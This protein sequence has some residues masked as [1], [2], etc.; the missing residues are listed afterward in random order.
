MVFQILFLLVLGL[1][2]YFLFKSIS[3]I[4]RNINLGKDEY[5][6]DQPAKRFKQMM[7]V[8][9]GQKKMFSRPVPAIL[10]L[11]V[12]V[13]F[14]LI[15][16]EVLEILID[17]IAG[18]HRIFLPFL[19]NFY[20]IVINFFEFLAVMVIVVCVVFLL[21]RNVFK[22]R[23][24]NMP[25]LKRFPLFDA[26]AVLVIEIVL[27]VALLAMN[28][29]DG[30]LQSRSHEHYGITGTLA[31]SQF[32][33]PVFMGLTTEKLVLLERTFWWFH[34]IG[35]LLFANYLPYSKHLHILM[36][37]PNT[38]FAKLELKGKFKN[39]PVVTR[40][41]KSMLSI[42]LDED[43]QL[44]ASNLHDTGKFGAKDIPDLSWKNLMDAYSCTEC[45]RCTSSCPANI[46]GKKLSPR[47]IMMDTRDRMEEI[48]R[49]LDK[50]KEIDSTKSLLG[51]YITSE[52][53]LACT[54]CN[55]CVEEC[56]INIDPLDIIMQLRR[57]KIMEEAKAPDSWN[58]MFSNL[59]N[60]QAP[61]K[62]SPSDR[63]NW[64]KEN[65]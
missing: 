65:S 57:Y 39:M 62:F 46:T 4:K 51:D 44:A 40:E 33:N 17:G 9:F 53:L 34:I 37:F 5:L 61:W 18:T 52:E 59:E 29:C 16:I 19:G 54:T 38:Y 14:V 55:A 23:R 25:E 41:V 3:R 24:L 28:A 27:M 43:E 42:P 49:H 50:N 31:F 63:L 26:N 1:A 11:F 60:N 48:G 10:H 32:L 45:G 56:P 7:L 36:A 12:Y 20:T 13:G 22:V 6:G 8:A 2:G 30:I 58:A 15:N 21:R 64:A 47:K 35:I